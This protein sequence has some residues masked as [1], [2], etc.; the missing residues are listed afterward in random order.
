MKKRDSFLFLF[1][2]IM[3]MLIF[4]IAASICVSVFAQAHRMNRESRE[5]NAATSAEKNVAE[6]ISASDGLDSAQS[7]ILETYPQA[8]IADA[9]D[10]ASE[11]AGAEN[12]FT[13]CIG[14][15]GDFQVTA[16]EAAKYLLKADVASDDRLMSADLH[17]YPVTENGAAGDSVYDL[18]VENAV[19]KTSGTDSGEAAS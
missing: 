1:E 7:L 19:D 8:E 6:L 5:L 15:D 18:H 16:R 9:S 4:F 13:V 3:A 14:F 2:M 11:S 10:A 17:Y 12:G